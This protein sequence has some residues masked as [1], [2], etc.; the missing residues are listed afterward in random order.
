MKTAFTYLRHFLVVL[1]LMLI[2]AAGIGLWMGADF[3][4]GNEMT[5]YSVGDEGPHVF[6]QGDQWMVQTLRG[7]RE[8]GFWVETQRH[9]LADT[10]PLHVSV[11]LDNSRFTLQ[12]TP[13]FAIPP[14]RYQDGEA[15]LAISDIEGN[16]RTFRDF[17]VNA[18]VIDRGLNW[19]FGKG[20][21]VLVGDFVDRGPS[22][23]Q[24]LWFIYKLEQDARR[25]GGQVHY[26]LGNHE[27]KNLQ[28]NIDAAND[29]YTNVA[30]ILG[31]NHAELFGNDAFLGRWLA[32]KN[33]VEVINDILFVHG[34]LHPS[35]AKATYTLDDL[36]RIVRAQY[37]Q[38]WYP[39]R[40]AD[41][42]ILLHPKTGPSWYR[43]YFKDDLTQAEVEQTLARFDATTVVVGHTLNSRVKTL[44]DG[45]VIAIDV[46]HPWDHRTGFP[47]RRSEG[48]R[49]QGNTAWRIL[50]D[51]SQVA[52]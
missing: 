47:P 12:A 33:T 9:A 39:R 23:T 3:H 36:N 20:H 37:R 48:V 11:P 8:G 34:G 46:K 10:L 45:K 6:Q 22:A 27:I 17:L 38:R 14:A 15:I 4:Y 40:D 42:D 25:Q 32:S 52:L 26:I 50:D 43:G 13:H 51:G 16:Y 29:I 1:L 49:M 35:L 41:D 31:R 28:G 2:P 18:K 7:N 30:A 19:T 44:F 24:V 21:L 5:D